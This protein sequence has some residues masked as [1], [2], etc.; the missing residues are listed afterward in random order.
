MKA[1]L[2]NSSVKAARFDVYKEI[3]A[4]LIKHRHEYKITAF[5]TIKSKL[6][7]FFSKFLYKIKQKLL[8]R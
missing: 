2:Y 5:N 7:T 1:Y 4:D 3:V 6:L 8:G